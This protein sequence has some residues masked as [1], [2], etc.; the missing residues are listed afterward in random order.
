MVSGW[1]K[2]FCQQLLPHFHNQKLFF[3]SMCCGFI[4]HM[5]KGQQPIRVHALVNGQHLR[6]GAE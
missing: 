1:E 6:S 4:V 5:V 3:V 2:E